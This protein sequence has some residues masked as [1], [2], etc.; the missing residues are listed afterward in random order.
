M[1]V[2]VFTATVMKRRN[3]L[4]E[5]V[6]AWIQANDVVT[7]Q[8]WVVQSSDQSFHCLSIVIFYE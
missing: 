4:G 1:K 5:E 2:K 7:L 3:E 8:T 6:T